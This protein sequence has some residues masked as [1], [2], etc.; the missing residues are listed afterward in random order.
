MTF[1]K[2]RFTGSPVSEIT[3]ATFFDLEIYDTQ[4]SYKVNM[5]NENNIFYSM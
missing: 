3:A 5:C 1:M 2:F 4:F